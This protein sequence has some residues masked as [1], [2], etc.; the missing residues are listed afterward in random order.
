MVDKRFG[1]SEGSAIG[2]RQAT[3]CNALNLARCDPKG[4]LARASVP[5]SP[6]PASTSRWL[7]A[8]PLAFVLL[9]STG[10]IVAKYAAPHAPPLT[11]LLYRFAG[12]VAILLPLIAITKAPWPRGANSWRDVMIV[13]VLL[14]ATYLGG[15]WFAIAM[16]MP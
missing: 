5:D 9:W 16:G 3:C 1:P 15:V 8:A 10:F 14:Q 12:A 4:P 6:P 13:G 2:V 7:S 11:F